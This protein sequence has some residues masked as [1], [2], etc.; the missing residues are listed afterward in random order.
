MIKSGQRQVPAYMRSALLSV[1]CA[2]EREVEPSGATN[3]VSR[4]SIA[5]IGVYGLMLTIGES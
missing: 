5:L 4:E 2:D 3:Y 1:S